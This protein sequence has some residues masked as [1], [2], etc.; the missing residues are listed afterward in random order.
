L[1][2]LMIVDFDRDGDPDILVADANASQ[3]LYYQNTMG[4]P[5]V[6]QG[7]VRSA[8]DNSPISQALVRL[9]DSEF[10]TFT[11]A[12]GAYRLAAAGGTYTLS[13]HHP[14]WN[15]TV[16]RNLTI[17]TGDTL[18][19]DFQLTHPILD[20]PVTSINLAVPNGQQHD[21]ELT[22][23]NPGDGPLFLT[24]QVTGNFPND[25]WLS[26]DP[27]SMEVPANSSSNLT[28]HVSP[29]TAR[30]L[31][32]DYYGRVVLRSNTCP[33]SIRN[34]AVVV[35]VLDAPDRNSLLPERTQMEPAFPNPFN[36]NT[37]IRLDLARSTEITA[38][39]YDLLGR[40]VTTLMAGRITAGSH[41]IGID[42]SDWAS[43]VYLIRVTAGSS[44]FTQ[45]LLLMK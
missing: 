7:S 15:D 27:T 38:I 25:P 2:D 5:A 13:I 32:A 20:C 35:Y 8:R 23:S 22:I 4:I 41:R 43:G 33:D 1:Y 29:D 3:I 6:V 9:Q 17:I 10:L 34:I 45:K 21:T 11:D 12:G 31:S 36:A 40:H 42:A 16:V 30:N 19:A 44:Q 28:V 37:S 18:V 24:A 14:C 39:V 26:V